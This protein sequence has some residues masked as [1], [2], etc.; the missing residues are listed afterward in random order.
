MVLP[1]L[2]SQDTNLVFAKYEYDSAINGPVNDCGNEVDLKGNL[3]P[4]LYNLK[5]LM[6]VHDF[7][8][9]WPLIHQKNY[10]VGLLSL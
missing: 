10:L 9:Q 8:P 6:Q 5:G 2:Q 4:D 1:V 7:L 3:N